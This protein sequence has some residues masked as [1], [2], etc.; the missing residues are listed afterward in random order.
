MTS[1]YPD[2]SDIFNRE[3]PESKSKNTS[4][5]LVKFLEDNDQFKYFSYI[6]RKAKLVDFFSK[7]DNQTVFIVNDKDMAKIGEDYFIKLSSHECRKLLLNHVVNR[8]IPPDSFELQH[9]FSVSSETG[10]L[11]IHNL[12]VNN[13]STITNSKQPMVI[14]G[15]IVYVLDNMLEN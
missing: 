5:G 8:L 10:D 14:G 4:K 6:M 12:V 11:F 7:A 15:N 13:K 3:E 2:S 9:Y 1:L